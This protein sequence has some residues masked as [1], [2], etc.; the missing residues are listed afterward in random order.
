[1]SLKTYKEINKSWSHS[2]L[3]S[4]PTTLVRML[5]PQQQPN[6]S[7]NLWGKK[8]APHLNWLYVHFFGPAIWH[9][10]GKQINRFESASDL[11]SLQKLWFT[12]CTCT[13]FWHFWLCPPTINEVLKWLMNTTGAHLNAEL[14]WW[15]HCSVRYSFPTAWDFVQASTSPDTT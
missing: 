2:Q 4:I 9:E 3:S 8:R 1:M 10:A 13:I 7:R 15:R 12:F 5:E 6:N 11:L 14:F